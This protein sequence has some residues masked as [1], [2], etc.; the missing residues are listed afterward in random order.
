M[1]ENEILDTPEKAKKR[2]PEYY[3]LSIILICLVL[4]G[5]FFRFM[6][7]SFAGLLI[8]LPSVF[9]FGL[10]LYKFFKK[11]KKRIEDYVVLSLIVVWMV[12]L[13]FYFFSVRL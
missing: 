12:Y 9:L 8:L 2:Q 1:Q 4:T 7:W 11:K 13:Y 5:Y 6:H 3:A 10:L